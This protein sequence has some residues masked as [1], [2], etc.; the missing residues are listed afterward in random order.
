MD[1]DSQ[2]QV[3]EFAAKYADRIPGSIILEIGSQNINGSCRPF[4]QGAKFYFG[5]DVLPG[6]EV[7]IVLIDPYKFPFVDG[8]FDFVISANC[9]EHCTRP[10]ETVKEAARVL[11]PGG[12]FFSSQPWKFD[13]HKD[14]RCPKDCYRILEDGM[15][16]LMD[17]AGLNVVAT[18]TVSEHCMGIGEKPNVI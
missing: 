17:Y 3:Q 8:F 13:V 9:L 4:F 11:K 1:P 16:A 2:R 6:P 7:D 15:I 12:L 5:I 14:A 10:W 18:G